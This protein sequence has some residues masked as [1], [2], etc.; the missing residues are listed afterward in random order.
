[1]AVLLALGVM[2][3]AWMVCVALVVLV[4]K[5]L[6]PKAAFDIPFALAVVGLGVATLAA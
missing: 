3:I 4:Q 2:N 5:V 1:M 6:P